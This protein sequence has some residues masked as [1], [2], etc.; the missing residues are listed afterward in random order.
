MSAL[1][2][3]LSR[4]QALLGQRSG[5]RPAARAVRCCRPKPF[6]AA[7]PVAV[8]STQDAEAPSTVTAEEL[9]GLIEDEEDL[10]LVEELEEMYATAAA[11][12]DDDDDVGDMEEEDWAAAEEAAELISKE[13][14]DAQWVAAVCAEVDEDEEDQAYAEAYASKLLDDKLVA[15]TVSL[16]DLGAL[17][18]DLDEAELEAVELEDMVPGQGSDRYEEVPASAEDLEVIEGYKLSKPELRN[19]LPEDWDQINTDFFSNKRDETIPLPEYRLNVLWTEKNLAVAIDQV[20][21]RGQVSPLTEYYLWPRQDA[22]EEL[23]MSLE[24]RPWISER[25]RII[26]LNRLT[27]LINF[28]QDE[29]VKHSVDEARSEFP[30]CA[31]AVA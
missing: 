19:L 13:G 8:R 9:A 18:A 6:T 16:S 5:S 4:Q 28:W 21:S 23:R 24:G 20:Y 1:V 2:A 7:R 12:G 27:Q 25:D 29:E 14:L 15:G 26:L 31:F 10:D 3:S 30:D 22:W 17:T 11:D